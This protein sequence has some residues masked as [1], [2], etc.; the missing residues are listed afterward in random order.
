MAKILLIEDDPRALEMLRFRFE[1]AGYDVTE[2]HD[3]D[4]GLTKAL[5]KPDLIVLDVRLPKI[6]GWELC[7]LLKNEPRTREIP[8]MMLTGCSQPVQEAYGKVCGAD[9]Y[10]TKPWEAGELMKVT[11]RLLSRAGE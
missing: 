7:R 2:A 1:K 3:G 9:E 8:I 4:D 11:K 6:D 10:L 5:H